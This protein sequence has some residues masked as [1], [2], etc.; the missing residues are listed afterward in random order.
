MQTRTTALATVVVAAFVVGTAS[1]GPGAGAATFAPTATATQIPIDVRTVDVCALFPGEQV[2]AA[3]GGRLVGTR[4]FQASD[5]TLRRCR[6]TVTP[7]GGKIGE[8]D[9]YLIWVLPPDDFAG[10]RD[11]EDKPVTDVGGVGDAAFV[12]FHQDEGRAW[13]TVLVLGRATLQISGPREP[14]VRRVA[15]LAVARVRAHLPAR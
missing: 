11:A 14:D 5:G 7:A 12:T 2:A 9:V 13:L 8:S 1:A 3:L 15:S 6:Y 10:L 4:P